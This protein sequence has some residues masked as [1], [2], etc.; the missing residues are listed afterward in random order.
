[1]YE[2]GTEGK[3]LAPALKGQLNLYHSDVSNA[4]DTVPL[5]DGSYQSQNFKKFTRQGGE[6]RLDY[7]ITKP[8]TVFTAADFNDVR[9][10]QTHKIVRD[11]GIARESFK[12]GSSYAWPFGFKVN[13]DGRYNRWSSTPGMANDRKPIFD[14]KLTQDFKN[15]RKDID[16]GV[17]FNVYNLTNSS[18]WSNPAFPLPGR[19]VEGGLTVS[20]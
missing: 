20:F 4:I 9:N 2:L 10:E 1:M 15:I 6:A 5:D 19:Y 11:E 13:L 7:A 8:W 16:L 14:L 18:Y 3:I 17:F 12:W